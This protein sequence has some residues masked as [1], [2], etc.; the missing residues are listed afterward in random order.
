MPAAGWTGPRDKG[1]GMKY[2]F[3]EKLREVRERKQKTL[4]EVAGQAGLSESLISQIER[5]RISPALDTLLKIIDVLEIDLDYVLRDFKRERQ[6]NLVRAGERNRAVI[7]G[8]VYEQLSHTASISQEHAMEAYSLEIP[9]GGKSGDEEVGHPGQ[10][11]G[12]IIKGTCECVVGK[13]VYALQAG[14]SISFAADI[15]HQLRNTGTKPLQAFW[16]MTPPKRLLG[17][18]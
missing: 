6:V 17:R 18:R 8:A 14:D 13:R 7:G 4:R 9:P 11:L 2:Q 15:P 3:G 16:V 10:E 5:N 1:E 12:V